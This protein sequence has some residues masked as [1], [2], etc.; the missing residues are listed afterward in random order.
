MADCAGVMGVE[1]RR[2]VKKLMQLFRQIKVGGLRIVTS[3]MVR[4]KR[5]LDLL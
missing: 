2:L 1:T 3:E 4:S 5:I